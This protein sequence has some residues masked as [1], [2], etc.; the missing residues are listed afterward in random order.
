MKI[1][2][3]GGSGFVGRALCQKLFESGYSILTTIRKKPHQLIENIEYISIPD[4]NQNTDWSNILKEIDIVVHTA[5]RVHMMNEKT[6]NPLEEYCKI[7]TEGTLNL[8]QQAIQANVKKFIFLSTIKVNGEET[9]EQ[10]FQ[11]TS[12]CNP[13][14]PYAL[15]KW[16]AEQ[17][18]ASIANNT[19]FDYTIVRLPLIYGQGVKANFSNLLKLIKSRFPLPF[20]AI[21]NKRSMLYIGNLSS[22]ILKIIESSLSKN[23]TYLLSDNEDISTAKLS[24]KIAYAYG[25]KIF[26]IPLPLFLFKWFGMIMG[27]RKAIS[28]LLGS[29]QIDSSKIRN[30]LNWL[31]PYTVELGLAEMIRFE[32]KVH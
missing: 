7:N 31:P 32:K 23:K 22:A 12:P 25:F 28:R 3:T 5:A 15:S 9:F 24:K 26:L 18:I 13:K 10:A 11:E 8:F 20:G 29:L 16:E 2:V 17:G 27:K 1:L 30:E 6:C 21:Q 14:D 4:I 19:N